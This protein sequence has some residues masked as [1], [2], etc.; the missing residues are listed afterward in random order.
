MKKLIP[1]LLSALLLASPSTALTITEPAGL[2]G[3]DLAVLL[4]DIYVIDG[5]VI[6]GTVI[7]DE[8]TPLTFTADSAVSLR[9][10]I[11]PSGSGLVADPAFAGMDKP[12]TAIVYG[13]FSAV[14]GTAPQE[15]TLTVTAEN[16][17][18]EKQERTYTFRIYP[19]PAITPSEPA[20]IV[21]GSPYT[22]RPS[23]S[24]VSSWE[25]DTE[26]T[27][28]DY[29]KELPDG[30]DFDSDTG[31]ISGTWKAPDGDK[32]LSFGT[33]SREL[34]RKI[35]I[36][37]SQEKGGKS[38]S[39]DY[40]LKFS[41]T[42]PAILENDGELTEKYFSKLMYGRDCDISIT[43]EAQGAVS[44]SVEGLPSGLETEH[45]DTDTSSTLRITG[46]PTM[47]VKDRTINITASNSR[48]SVKI[49]PKITVGYD[50][51]PE[52]IDGTEENAPKGIY[53]LG[54]NVADEAVDYDFNDGTIT[55]SSGNPAD[56][57]IKVFP[58]PLAWKT[59][60][61]PAG[62]TLSHDRNGG[63]EAQFTGTFTKA[64]TYS[65]T[66][67][68]TNTALNRSAELTGTITVYAKPEITTAKLPEITVSRPYSAKLAARNNPANWKITFASGGGLTDDKFNENDDTYNADGSSSSELTWNTGNLAIEGTLDAV[69]PGG[70]FSVRAEAVNPAGSDT[71][72]FTVD[73]KGTPPTIRTASI[74]NMNAN[75][76]GTVDITATGTLPITLG[77]YIDAATAKTVFG[78][79]GKTTIDLMDENNITGFVFDPDEEDGTGT[80]DLVRDSGVSYKNLPVTISAANYAVQKPV[81]K[82]L[83][84]TV[85]GEAPKIYMLQDGRENELRSASMNITAG[86][87][88]KTE[89]YAFRVRGSRPLTITSSLGWG[90]ARAKNG[91]Y[92]VMKSGEGYTDITIYAAPLRGSKENRTAV[93]LTAVNPSTRAQSARTITVIRRPVRR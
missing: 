28:D 38:A 23:A 82:T 56:R 86:R 52:F 9:A 13:T 87:D 58:G 11:T 66:I 35:R 60:G 65:Y 34:T 89:E 44:W 83:R 90:E 76:G 85:A 73:A 75:E 78:L 4:E 70:K 77:A 5:A 68:A 10:S 69:P 42:A 8:D 74:P 26:G 80:L 91:V 59:A 53:A 61:L 72:I 30:L 39:R 25:I 1:A 41:L 51:S 64:G 84:A 16:S 40:E 93:K 57:T 79:D 22:F 88:G 18:G 45:D 36:R 27:G 55:P 33:D 92:T 14:Q 20:A 12:L 31:T 67:T 81:T 54:M 37:A 62:I 47:L 43:A 7:T 6:G 50:G 3:N 71:K 2:S 24:G 15:Y 46:T 29:L 63:T 17:S 48:G 21:W 32:G 19:A 49:A